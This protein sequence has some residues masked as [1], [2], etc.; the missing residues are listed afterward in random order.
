LT[1]S[2]DKSSPQT[3]IR[4]TRILHF[5]RRVLEAVRP[6]SQEARDAI[7]PF[8]ALKAIPDMPINNHSDLAVWK[9]QVQSVRDSVRRL[10]LQLAESEAGADARGRRKIEH[11]KIKL[12]EVLAFKDKQVEMADF[13]YSRYHE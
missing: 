1:E 3:G 8:F 13:L 2:D 5:A 10:L 6:P 7:W 4:A 11:L 12:R 9:G